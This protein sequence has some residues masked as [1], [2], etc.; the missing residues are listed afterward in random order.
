MFAR[1]Q[2]CLPSTSISKLEFRT[3]H[4]I[5]HRS[6]QYVRNYKPLLAQSI[7]AVGL[8]V[9]LTERNADY[10]YIVDEEYEDTKDYVMI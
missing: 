9:Y 5:K 6:G 2:E 4:F 10:N 8:T 3:H 1:A 7:V